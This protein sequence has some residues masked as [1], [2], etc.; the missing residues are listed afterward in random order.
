MSCAN[1]NMTGKKITWLEFILL[2][3]DNMGCDI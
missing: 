3:D 2:F 1:E